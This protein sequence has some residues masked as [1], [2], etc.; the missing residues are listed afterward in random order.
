MNCCTLMIWCIY[1]L[2]KYIACLIQ[3]QHMCLYCEV[4]I[5]SENNNMISLND[6]N[7]SL[8][9]LKSSNKKWD[10]VATKTKPVVMCIGFTYTDYS[11]GNYWE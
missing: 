4:Y 3:S 2:F 7:C 10:R 9:I 8:V 5:V 1:L 6:V 11:T